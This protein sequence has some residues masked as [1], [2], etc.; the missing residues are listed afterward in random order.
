MTPP[1]PIHKSIFITIIIISTSMII[2]NAQHITITTLLAILYLVNQTSI[3]LRQACRY[4][5]TQYYALYKTPYSHLITNRPHYRQYIIYQTL[6]QKL[7][8]NSELLISHHP[9]TVLLIH[10]SCV[11]I[12]YTTH[13]FPPLKTISMLHPKTKHDVI[14]QT[15]TLQTRKPIYPSPKR[16]QFYDAILTNKKIPYF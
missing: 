13:P 3:T 14:K 10:P 15:D 6:L 4:K 9:Y 1:T 11:C 12:F 7:A 8:H 2:F 16:M 5:R